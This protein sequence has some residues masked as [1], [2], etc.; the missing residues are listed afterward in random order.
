MVTD[1]RGSTGQCYEGAGRQGKDKWGKTRIWWLTRDSSGRQC[2]EDKAQRMEGGWCVC[3]GE[4]TWL[5]GRVWRRQM[6]RVG[7]GPDL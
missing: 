1:V 3:A 5:K 7:Q 4:A 2:G 6:G